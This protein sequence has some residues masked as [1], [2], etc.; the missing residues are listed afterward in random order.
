MTS[1]DAWR[2]T[3]SAHTRSAAEARAAGI[4]D[5]VVEPDALVRLA[6]RAAQRLTRL[7]SHALARMRAWA[8][9][10]RRHPLADAVSMGAAIIS[11]L[12]VRP[13]VKR[14]WHAYA[15]GDAPWSV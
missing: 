8:R 6:N 12:A 5:E 10:C 3:I 4:V 13:E 1:H 14:R 2:W 11:D 15:K 9:D 7:E